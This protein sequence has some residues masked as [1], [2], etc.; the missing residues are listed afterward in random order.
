MP[1]ENCGTSDEAPKPLWISWDCCPDQTPAAMVTLKP[2]TSV[3][4][5]ADDKL[6]QL[7]ALLRTSPAS[8]GYAAYVRAMPF[9]VVPEAAETLK[10]TLARARALEEQ[11]AAALDDTAESLA[12]MELAANRRAA[13]AEAA[14]GAAPRGAWGAD[15]GG[16]GGGGGQAGAA[17]V[18]GEGGRDARAR[19]RADAGGQ[20][21]RGGGRGRP[22]SGGG[23]G[24][25]GCGG[26]AGGDG[27]GP[28]WRGGRVR[29]RGGARV[30]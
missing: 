2:P 22:G 3:T 19:D 16:G 20:R 10:P 15:G 25:F 12:E 9:W 30:T 11:A 17:G 13:E 28:C 27:A 4:A 6:Q 1:A 14:A 26:G 8:R 18:G 29:R 23:G 5:P 24:D 7:L 21:R